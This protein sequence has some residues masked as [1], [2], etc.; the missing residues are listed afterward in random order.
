MSNFFRDYFDP[1]NTPYNHKQFA[2]FTAA[3]ALGV[4]LG[5]YI[6]HFSYAALIAVAIG[7]LLSLFKLYQAS[8][9]ALKITNND[10][11]TAST[12]SMASM[13]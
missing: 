2:T 4:A 12:L 10:H 9:A 7:A 1:N 13:R 3:I 8:A 5:L 6:K 11:V